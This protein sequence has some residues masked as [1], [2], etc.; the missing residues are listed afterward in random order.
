MG[1]RTGLDDDEKRKFLN[2]SELELPSGIFP[3]ASHTNIPFAALFFPF[4]LHLIFLDLIILFI[5]AVR[6]KMTCRLLILK[7]SVCKIPR[8]EVLENLTLPPRNYAPFK[9]NDVAVFTTDH[10]PTLT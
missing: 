10:H 4:L 7:R 2:S 3:C 5:F 9:E 6:C 8:S 1:P